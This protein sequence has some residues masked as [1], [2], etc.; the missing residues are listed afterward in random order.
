MIDKSIVTFIIDKNKDNSF[1]IIIHFFHKKFKHRPINKPLLDPLCNRAHSSSLASTGYM[2]VAAYRRFGFRDGKVAVRVQMWG[3]MH[4]HS[5]DPPSRQSS[6]PLRTQ[7]LP[8]GMGHIHSQ[9]L[10]WHTRSKAPGK[11]CNVSLGP[12]RSR[13]TEEHNWA[14]ICKPKSSHLPCTSVML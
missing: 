6:R 9:A 4:W 1:K 7:T 8:S 12:L 5:Y 3:E 2:P 13:S 11:K 14:E 10:E